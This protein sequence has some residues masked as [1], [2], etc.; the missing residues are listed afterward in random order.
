MYIL[1]TVTWGGKDKI[2]PKCHTQR[3]S[4]E[5]E[6]TD[7]VYEICQQDLRFLYIQRRISTK[8]S[9]FRQ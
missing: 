5:S 7:T 1:E 8:D 4:V 9:A 6:K 2:G 3:L